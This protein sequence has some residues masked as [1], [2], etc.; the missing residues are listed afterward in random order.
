MTTQRDLK[1]QYFERNT[2]VNQKGLHLDL[3]TIIFGF[4][5]SL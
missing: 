2:L 4:F 1:R 5:F 3:S